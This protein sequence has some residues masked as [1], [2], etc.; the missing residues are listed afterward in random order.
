MGN[1]HS[2]WKLPG[3]GPR[4]GFLRLD[5]FR[6]WRRQCTTWE[7][8]FIGLFMTI[9][10]TRNE[11]GVV[12][13]IF[14][15]TTAPPAPQYALLFESPRYITYLGRSRLTQSARPVRS[16]WD[17]RLV[18][19][20]KRVASGAGSMTLPIYAGLEVRLVGLK[21]LP[22]SLWCLGAQAA[23]IAPVYR[24]DCVICEPCFTVMNNLGNVCAENTRDAAICG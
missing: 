2:R 14:H 5:L 16:G 21:Q 3:M 4:D 10:Q 22:I 8:V 1:N 20:I 12:C 6:R 17:L 11:R 15:H 23:G 9:E 7:R 13:L 24:Q 18:I 19:R